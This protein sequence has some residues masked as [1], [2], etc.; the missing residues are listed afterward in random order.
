VTVEIGASRP[1]ETVKQAVYPVEQDGKYDMLISLLSNAGSG[2]VLVF[3]R[4]KHRA[5]KLA[6]LLVKAG[7]SATSL[8]G[9]LSQNQRQLAMDRFRSGRVQVMVATD[10][11]AR[12]IDVSQVSHVINYDVPDTAEAYTHRVGRTG[13][14]ERLGTAFTFATQE[15]L[16]MIRSIE[17]L[18]GKPLPRVQHSPARASL[19]VEQPVQVEIL[20]REPV[21]VAA[22]PVYPARTGSN[23][24]R[25]SSSRPAGNRDYRGSPAHSQQNQ[26]Q[27]NEHKWGK[28]LSSRG[29]SFK[30]TSERKEQ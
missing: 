21:P 4:T 17:R 20:R 26:P 27:D 28:N 9:N 23:G 13:R 22:R 16:P 12:G 1:V 29:S 14:M 2:Q 6:M 8:Q 30:R 5:K 18:M 10:I 25:P 15:D 3:T 24:S 11:A 19:P 7:L